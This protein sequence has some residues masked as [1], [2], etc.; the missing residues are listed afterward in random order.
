METRPL[1]A[2]SAQCV[3][4]RPLTAQGLTGHLPRKEENSENVR[5]L[6]RPSVTVQAKFCT[7]Q[8][9]TWTWEAL[10]QAC[11]HLS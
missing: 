9:G 1:R 6:G 10:A 3:A 4:V 7:V 2:P 5:K 11:G 8:M